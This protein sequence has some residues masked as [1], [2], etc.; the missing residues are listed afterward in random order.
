V[1]SSVVIISG[2]S[3]IEHYRLIAQQF[4]MP[5]NFSDEEY[6]VVIISPAI[7]FARAQYGFRAPEVSAANG[8]V[9]IL[10]GINLVLSLIRLDVISII[11]TLILMYF[12][13]FTYSNKIPGAT[14][15]DDLRR[16]FFA[17]GIPD[18]QAKIRIPSEV[19]EYVELINKLRNHLQQR[20]KNEANNKN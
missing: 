20:N 8:W 17:L 15:Q 1:L 16:I 3:W 12:A 6:A 18:K 9:Q 7:T 13:A 10:L 4:K 14:P 19:E 5:I 11:I 2:F